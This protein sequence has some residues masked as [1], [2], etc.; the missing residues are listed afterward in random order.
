MCALPAL[1]QQ[2]YPHC[3]HNSTRQRYS[4][5]RGFTMPHEKELR[6]CACHLRDWSSGENSKL[7]SSF[8]EMPDPELVFSRP[9]LATPFFILGEI[10]NENKFLGFL[11]YLDS[12]SGPTTY[13]YCDFP[14]TV[15]SGNSWRRWSFVIAFIISSSQIVLCTNFRRPKFKTTW[16]PKSPA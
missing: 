1:E 13:T 14:L 7:V 16:P 2:V 15:E 10:G 3:E 6:F 5:P 4:D 12:D 11:G 8:L 9:V